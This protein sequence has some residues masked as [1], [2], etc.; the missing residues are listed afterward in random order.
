MR[1][2]SRHFGELHGAEASQDAV[3]RA[4]EYLRD[5]PN[6]RVERLSVDSAALMALVECFKQIRR[7]VRVRSGAARAAST[8]V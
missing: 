3:N 4:Q 1:A 8:V 7:L 5:V 6:T 2:M